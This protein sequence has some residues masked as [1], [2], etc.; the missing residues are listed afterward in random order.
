MGPTWTCWLG[1]CQRWSRPDRTVKLCL[2]LGSSTLH[3]LWTR[4]DRLDENCVP[5][6]VIKSLANPHCQTSV[7]EHICYCNVPSHLHES[8]QRDWTPHRS[9]SHPGIIHF[10]A[11]NLLTR[12]L[13]RADVYSNPDLFTLALHQVQDSLQDSC[14]YCCFLSPAGLWGHLIRVWCLLL[15]P[16]SKLKQAPYLQALVFFFINFFFYTFNF[17]FL[18]LLLWHCDLDT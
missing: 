2:L 17:V 4:S 1:C 11:A 18:S 12:S 13:N 16:D 8:G 7:R 10:S 3:W 6:K 14:H 9:C 5:T 15:V